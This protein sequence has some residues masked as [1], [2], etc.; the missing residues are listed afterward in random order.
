MMLPDD[1]LRAVA[2]AVHAVGGLFVLDC[3]ASGTMWVDMQ[4]QRRRRADQRAAEGLEQLAV[5]RAGDAVASARAS[6]IDGTTSTSF[7]CDLRSGC[8]SWKPTRSGGHAY[9]ATHADRR[10][11]ARCA[12]RCG[13][14]SGYG[15]EAAR[16]TQ[17]S[18]GDKVRALLASA[19]HCRASRRTGFEAPGVVVS[20]TDDPDIH[21]GAQVHRS[22]ACRRR[23]ACRCNATSPPTS[24]R[25]ASACSA[26]TSCTTSIARCASSRRRCARCANDSRR[27]SP[28]SRR[29]PAPD[30]CGAQHG[31]ALDPAGGEV[32]QDDICLVERLRP[33]R[34]RRQPAGASDRHQLGHL[35][36]LP[37]YDPTMVAAFMVIIVGETGVAPPNRPTETSGRVSQRAEAEGEGRAGA[38]EVDRRKPAACLL[39]ERLQRAVGRRVDQLAGGA[40]RASPIRTVISATIARS[41]SGRGAS[42][43][44]TA[45]RRPRR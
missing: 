41:P 35:G 37:T 1:Y 28:P 10:A 18:S 39:N 21:T 36:R 40:S 23:P 22:R 20:Y 7:A 17:R 24:G 29:G 32:R 3:I 19:R 27:R 12:T 25:S 34:H 9:H 6:A 42:R 43:S 30:D 14:P 4:R 16:A 13:R 11:D 5:L 8:R 15:F 31:P 2:D 33:Q 26:S 38:D 45:R 44:P